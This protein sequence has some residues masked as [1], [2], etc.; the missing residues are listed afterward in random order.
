[1][2][3][4]V[5]DAS[6][7]TPGGGPVNVKVCPP[8]VTVTGPVGNPVTVQAESVVS[9]PGGRNGGAPSGAPVVGGWPVKGKSE[10]GVAWALVK[11]MVARALRRIAVFI[12]EVG[13]G[14]F[15]SRRLMRWEPRRWLMLEEDRESN[16]RMNERLDFKEKT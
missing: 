8:R 1:M 16:E 14:L 2:K 4:R 10:G 13:L 3:V 11:A 9:Q 7:G 12:L 15:E 6:V 5:K